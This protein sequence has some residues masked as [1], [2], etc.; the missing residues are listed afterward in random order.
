MNWNT[1]LGVSVVAALLT[2]IGTLW[3]WFSSTLCL[4]A[5]SEKWKLHQSLREVS[6]KYGDPIHFLRSSLPNRLMPRKRRQPNQ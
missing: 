3:A 6:R 4:Q 1:L 5:R 2:T